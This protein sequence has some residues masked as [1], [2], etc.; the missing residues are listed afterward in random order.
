MSMDSAPIVISV[1][2]MRAALLS[3]KHGDLML[4]LQ[5]EGFG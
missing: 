2:L 3:P 1:V 5:Q 4:G